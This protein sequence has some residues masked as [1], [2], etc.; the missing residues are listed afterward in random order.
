MSGKLSSILVII[1]GVALLIGMLYSFFLILFPKKKSDTV[2]KK[3]KKS[4]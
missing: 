2:D 1:I 3:N 4:A